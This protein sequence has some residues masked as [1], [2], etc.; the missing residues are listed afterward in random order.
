MRSGKQ[1]GAD[2]Y[3]IEYRDDHINEPDDYPPYFIHYTGGLDKERQIHDERSHLPPWVQQLAANRLR[4]ELK[5]HSRGELRYFEL[6]Q[7]AYWPALMFDFTSSSNRHAR[8]YDQAL[9]FYL[10][11]IRPKGNKASPRGVVP[12]YCLM[13]QLGAKPA[14]PRDKLYRRPTPYENGVWHAPVAPHRLTYSLKWP[15]E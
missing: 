8:T 11:R 15:K 7:L 5:L 13:A 6:R 10:S 4:L 12:L 14:W 9:D 1:V 3:V 2:V